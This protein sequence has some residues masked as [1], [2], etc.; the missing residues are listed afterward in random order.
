[1]MTNLNVFII[2]V[3]MISDMDAFGDHRPLFRK[4]ESLLFCLSHLGL[5]PMELNGHRPL[6]C[7]PQSLS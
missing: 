1:M 3:K 5:S 7:Y 4:T 2:Q 6:T